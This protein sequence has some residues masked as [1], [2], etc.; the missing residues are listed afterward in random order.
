MRN[1]EIAVKYV[2]DGEVGWIT[3]VRRWKKSARCESSG[4][5]NDKRSL[6]S[7]GRWTG[8]QN[9]YLGKPESFEM[10]GSETQSYCLEN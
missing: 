6:G 7:T 8:S 2:K 3:V 4:N 1:R 9:L 10:G 5:M